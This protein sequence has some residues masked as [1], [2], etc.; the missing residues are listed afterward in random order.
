MTRQRLESGPTASKTCYLTHSAVGTIGK[1][2]KHQWNLKKY[3]KRQRYEPRP[4]ASETCYPTHCAM[5]TTA[6][7]DK[8]QSNH[9]KICHGRDSNPYLPLLTLVVLPTVPWEQME[10][11]TNVS[12]IV[13]KYGT[14]E[15]RTRTYFFKS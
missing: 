4:T 7:S 14:T 3:M 2:D 8:R 11:L 10:I 15:T 1:S 13:K 6:S 9:K 5:G 12:E